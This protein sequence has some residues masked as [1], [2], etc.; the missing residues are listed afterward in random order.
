MTNL[1]QLRTRLKLSQEQTFPLHFQEF[2]LE[3]SV[4]AGV[5]SSLDFQSW[6]WYADNFPPVAGKSIL[7]IGCGFGLPGLY[8]AKLGAASLVASDISPEAVTNTREN[9][10]R[11]DIQNVEVIESDI[12]SNIP[13]HRKFDFIFW[14]C[15]S[16]FAPDDYEYRDNLERAAINPGYKLLSRFLSEGPEFLTESGS[17]LLG[18]ASDARDDLLSEII[19]V[20]DLAS[21]L[22]GSGTYPHVSVTWRIFSIRKKGA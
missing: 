2:G 19:D 13:R 14:N 6:R 20:N 12:F 4:N 11:N 9:V 3:L 21:V 17:I 8:L 5:F 7:E 15:P 18:F 22:L 16:I 10:A 1:D